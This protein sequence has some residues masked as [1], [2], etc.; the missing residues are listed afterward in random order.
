[1]RPVAPRPRYTPGISPAKL[2]WLTLA[3][4]VG[5]PLVFV[6]GSALVTQDLSQRPAPCHPEDTRCLAY[7]AP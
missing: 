5:L 7:R 3:F 4:I 1:M 6:I 2:L